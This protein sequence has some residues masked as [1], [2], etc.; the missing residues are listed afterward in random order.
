[1][2]GE[3]TVLARLTRKIEK[4]KPETQGQPVPGMQLSREQRRKG[5]QSRSLTVRLQYPAAV[6][7]VVGIYR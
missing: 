7:S 3:V 1:M 2:E 5:G 6:V 4:G